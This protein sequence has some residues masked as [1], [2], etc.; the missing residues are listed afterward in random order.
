MRTTESLNASV[1]RKAPAL[2]TLDTVS[3]SGF[4][5]DRI[6]KV[7]EFSRTAAAIAVAASVLA[8]AGCGSDDTEPNPSAAS[9]T[10]AATAPAASTSAPT[11]TTI[12]SEQ[13]QPA[14]AAGWP[15]KWCAL[16]PKNTK[17]E[18]RAAMGPPT[19]AQPEDDGWYAFGYGFAAF[20]DEEGNVRQL[21][22][23]MSSAT[24]AQKAKV[25]CESGRRP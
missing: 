1:H 24:P 17:A 19:Q 5:L 20:Y 2:Q 4:F 15:A 13:V 3:T 11:A 9:P 8:A 10:P 7:S 14:T 21:D 18:I 23:N 16:T 25:T 6:A 12:A 22:V